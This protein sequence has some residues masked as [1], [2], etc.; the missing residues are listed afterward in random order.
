MTFW[1]KKE[2]DSPPESTYT[3]EIEPVNISDGRHELNGI[4]ISFSKPGWNWTILEH[5]PNRWPRVF[6]IGHGYHTRDE[7]LVDLLATVK[8]LNAPIETSDESTQRT[9]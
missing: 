8:D 3:Y 5:V 2:Q 7:A 1:K 4:E 9:T 6:R